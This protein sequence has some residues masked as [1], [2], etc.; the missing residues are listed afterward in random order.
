MK[1]FTLILLLLA[2]AVPAFAQE[3]R[4]RLAWDRVL[5]AEGYDVYFGVQTRIY[6][7][8][9][10]VLETNCG[11]DPAIC[12]IDFAVGQGDINIYCA[13]KAKNTMGS[14]VDYSREVV[15]FPAPEVT[16]VPTTCNPVAGGGV[17]CQAAIAGFNFAPGATA[18]ITYPGV[19]VTGFQRLDARSMTIDFDISSDA[20]GGSAELVVRNPWNVTAGTERPGDTYPTSGTAGRTFPDS[21]TVT[22]VVLPASPTNTRYI[23]R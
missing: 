17:T 16:A 8:P 6:G 19:T 2:L 1:R 3:N 15:S 7:T 9:V 4:M 11:S 20:M 21:I 18:N 22:P 13:V 5:G 10:E 12:E 14:S 23:D